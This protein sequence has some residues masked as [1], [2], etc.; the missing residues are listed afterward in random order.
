MLLDGV[1]PNVVLCSLGVTVGAYGVGQL[2]GALFLT[3]FASATAGCN[4]LDLSNGTL[5]VDSGYS[6]QSIQA[7]A[8]LTGVVPLAGAELRPELALT[9]GCTWIGAVDLTGT[10]YGGSSTLTFDAGDVTLATLAF[11]PEIV[12]PPDGL[13]VAEALSLASFTPGLT[14]ERASGIETWTDCGCTGALPCAWYQASGRAGS[15]PMSTSCASAR[16]RTRRSALVWNSGSDPARYP[17]A[18]FAM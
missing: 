3:G 9:L 16:G 8:S 12:I 13:P 1:G 2:S 10:A 14:C 15:A 7:G 6:T 4:D 11:R 17:A 5:V 18:A